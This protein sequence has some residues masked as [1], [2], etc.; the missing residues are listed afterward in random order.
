MDGNIL[1]LEDG[2][3]RGAETG[4]IGRDCGIDG[5]VGVVGVGGGTGKGWM[6]GGMMGSLHTSGRPWS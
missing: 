1:I 3:W 5:V 4:G 6:T 2:M